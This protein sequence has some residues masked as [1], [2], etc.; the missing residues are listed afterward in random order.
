M[1][2]R[3]CHRWLSRAVRMNRSSVGP[4]FPIRRASK[5]LTFALAVPDVVT[6]Y[7]VK[8]GDTLWGIASEHSINVSDLQQLNEDLFPR[9]PRC[10]ASARN[11]FRPDDTIFPGDKLYLPRHAINSKEQHIAEAEDSTGMGNNALPSVCDMQAAA[12]VSAGGTLTSRTEQIRPTQGSSDPVPGSALSV[13][14]FVGLVAV[15]YGIVRRIS[16]DPKSQGAATDTPAMK[17][18]NEDIIAYSADDVTGRHIKSGFAVPSNLHNTTVPASAQEQS[19][20][21]PIL[22]GATSA[23]APRAA[24]RDGKSQMDEHSSAVT[25]E[26]L[27]V[28]RSPSK[29]EFVPAVAED[30][31]AKA[32][33]NRLLPVLLHATES[34]MWDQLPSDANSGAGP[35]GDSDGGPVP[36]GGSNGYPAFS[37][38]GHEPHIEPSAA[39]DGTVESQATPYV[40]M[41]VTGSVHDDVAPGLDTVLEQKHAGTGQQNSPIKHALTKRFAG[42]HDWK[43]MTACLY[44]CARK[45]SLSSHRHRRKI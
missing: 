27:A 40:A 24:L 13:L 15:G 33:A 4:S 34:D 38:H 41:D 17:S 14:G 16:P 2:S 20:V 44:M 7:T 36:G 28:F 35:E 12:M 5:R 18:M 45:L 3:S 6:I 43:P 26:E 42:V 29:F 22:Q 30:G 25:D 39:E 32:A 23:A 8:A 1:H 9:R 31:N 37:E 21:Q 11:S 19:L 10:G